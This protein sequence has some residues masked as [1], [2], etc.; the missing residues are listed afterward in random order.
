MN[1]ELQDILLSLTP[2]LWITTGLILSIMIAILA[3]IFAVLIHN[4]F[5]KFIKPKTDTQNNIEFI[6][7]AKKL[8]TKIK[9]HISV[10]KLIAYVLPI[11]IG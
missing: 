10:V 9:T 4:D 11:M 2:N 5:V 8:N 1:K 6:N 3:L 7:M